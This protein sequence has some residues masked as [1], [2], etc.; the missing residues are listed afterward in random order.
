MTDTQKKKKFPQI[1][2]PRG[3]FKYP[4]LSEPDYGTKDYPK[5]DGE[6]GL[7]LV[8]EADS[9][10]AKA[11]IAALDPHYKEALAEGEAEFA[12]L[13]IQSR[14][15]L[16]AMTPHPFFNEVYDKETE[17]PTG[18]IEFNIKARAGGTYKSGPNKG[19]KWSFT[20]LLFDA[21]GKRIA[22]VPAIWSGTEGKVRFEVRPFF[23]S[24]TGLAG[25]SLKLQGVQ[26]LD[27]VSQGERSAESMGFGAE[28]GYV[29]PAGGGTTGGDTAHVDDA[30]D[31][32][33]ADF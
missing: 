12:K 16:K 30:G 4:K 14:K 2:S 18:E 21:A 17:E 5:P 29:A 27:L 31:D 9:P 10:G 15:K 33:S 19:K 26:I 22:D 28:D 11:L 32:E 20:P 6:Y 24:G 23:V 8:L 1:T 13:P 7:K 3:K 25:L